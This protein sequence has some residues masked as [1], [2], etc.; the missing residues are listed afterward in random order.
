VNTLFWGGGGVH[1]EIIP[2]IKF[3]GNSVGPSV[4]LTG[5]LPLT[6][7]PSLRSGGK[8]GGVLLS[9]YSIFLFTILLAKNFFFRNKNIDANA[10]A[11]LSRNFADAC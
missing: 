11:S 9:I 4:S 5:H 10:K 2:A 3:A 6:G 7:F 1:Q 8:G